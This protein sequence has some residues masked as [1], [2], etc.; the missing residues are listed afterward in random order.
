MKTTFRIIVESNEGGH[1]LN[2]PHY[3][4]LAEGVGCAVRNAYK[5]FLADRRPRRVTVTIQNTPPAKKPPAKKGTP[6]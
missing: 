6:A 1:E 2:Y 5:E 3:G 4:S